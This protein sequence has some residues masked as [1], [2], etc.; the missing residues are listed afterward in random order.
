MAWGV[1]RQAWE[2]IKRKTQPKE[3]PSCVCA[4]YIVHI[5]ITIMYTQY[6]YIHIC[7]CILLVHCIFIVSPCLRGTGRRAR[8]G[9]YEGSHEKDQ[10]E[11]NSEALFLKV[12]AGGRFHHPIL[13]L[14]TFFEFEFQDRYIRRTGSFCAFGLQRETQQ[15]WFNL[16]A[17]LAPLPALAGGGERGGPCAHT[18]RAAARVRR[19]ARFAPPSLPSA[20]P[21][22]LDEPDLKVRLAPVAVG[23]ARR[24]GA[25]AVRGALVA[26]AVGAGRTV[27]PDEEVIIQ[28]K[29]W[30]GGWLDVLVEGGT[31]GDG[32]VALG[33]AGAQP[34]EVVA[35]GGVVV[36]GGALAGIPLDSA[37]PFLG[38]APLRLG[39]NAHTRRGGQH[40]GNRTEG[41]Q[42]LNSCI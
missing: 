6:I 12:I 9:G 34:V 5:Y 26:P 20:L 2:T 11:I 33:L 18:C 41:Q 42:N 35:A 4:L 39:T 37:A 19:S 16:Q 23:P 13:L 36:A 15:Q 8:A 28:A 25:A 38:P 29:G 10:Q 1:P 30:P 3:S 24:V 7:I 27:V 40:T 22:A 32:F 21:R 17:Q 31:P 14:S